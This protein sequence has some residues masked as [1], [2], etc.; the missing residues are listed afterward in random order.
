MG[1]GGHY[2]VLVFLILSTL[3]WKQATGIFWCMIAGKYG[4]HYWHSFFY[5]NILVPIEVLALGSAA[6]LIHENVLS[7]PQMY[8]TEG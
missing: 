7:A 4:G 2:A 5:H 8:Q 6:C 1:H 3:D